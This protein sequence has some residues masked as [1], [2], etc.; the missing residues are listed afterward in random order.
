MEVLLPLPA[1]VLVKLVRNTMRCSRG[2]CPRA[3]GQEEDSRLE[4]RNDASADLRWAPSEVL[5]ELQVSTCLT[6]LS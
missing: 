4:R 3:S 1:P 6:N 2:F 5:L